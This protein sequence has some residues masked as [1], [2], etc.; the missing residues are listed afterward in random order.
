M[1]AAKRDQNWT[2]TLQ[3][4]HEIETTQNCNAATQRS[5]EFRSYSDT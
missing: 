5:R 3:E 4:N 2:K 1:I